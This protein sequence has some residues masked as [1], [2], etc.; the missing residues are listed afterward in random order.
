VI[1][2]RCA[3]FRRQL[4][5]QYNVIFKDWSSSSEPETKIEDKH[6]AAVPAAPVGSLSPVAAG[7]KDS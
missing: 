5:E 3:D 1:A 2:A 4:D 6:Q 7:R